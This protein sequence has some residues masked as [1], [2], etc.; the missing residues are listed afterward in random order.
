MS[1]P[2]IIR[3]DLPEMPPR[4]AALQV[5]PVRGYPVP[6]FVAW[7]DGKP[8]FRMADGTKMRRAIREKLCWVCG[9]KLDQNLAFLIGPMCAVNRISAEP[10]SHPKCAKFS[11]RACPFL[12]KPQMDRR[13]NDL[14]PSGGCAGIM[15]RRNPGVSLIWVTRSYSL[16][17]DGNGVLFRIGEPIA[18]TA[19]REG[20]VATTDEIR[21]SFDSG[22]PKLQEMALAQGA[23]AVTELAKVAALA[24]KRLG[25]E[26][27]G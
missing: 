7:V 26:V 1:A 27:E 23:E 10:P 24:R 9:Q 11:V 25:I 13:E 12:S 16:V 4:I 17:K 14:P 2:T 21:E 15:I 5:D 18:L 3:P 22:L 20:R 6:W 19:W 8:E